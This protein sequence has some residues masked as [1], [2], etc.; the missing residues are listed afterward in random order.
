MQAAK[1]ALTLGEQVKALLEGCEKNGITISGTG[2]S[3]KNVSRFLDQS[4]H[5]PS[6]S[7][8]LLKQWKQKIEHDLDLQGVK[9]EY[10]SLFGRLV[11]EWIENPNDAAASHTR[12]RSDSDS[13]D[14][15]VSLE[16][17][18]REEMHEQRKEWESYAFN[19]KPVHEAEIEKYL[20]AL[21]GTTH[22]SKNLKRTPLEEIRYG[23]GDIENM[24][25]VRFDA[26]TVSTCIK[27]VIRADLFAG[28]K[29]EALLD[30][31]NRNDILSEMADVLNMD[32]DSLEEWEWNPQPVQLHMRRQLS[33]KYR[34]F[35]D[36]DLHQAILLQF[37]GTK[38][39]IRLK[40]TFSAFFH[41]GAWLNDP[42]HAIGKRDR[43]RRE[44]FL[45]NAAGLRNKYTVRDARRTEFHNDSF[46]TQLSNPFQGA[47]RDYGD[48]EDED[49]HDPDERKTPMATKQGMLRLATTELLINT[50][51]YGEFTILQSDFKWFG[52]SLPHQT[53][54]TVLK[55]F[56]VKDKWLSFIRKFL[57]TPLVFAQDGEDGSVRKRRR[58]IPMSHV[59][60]DTLGE[61]VLFCLDFAV[62]QRTKGGNIYRFHD[63]LW[64]WGQESAC[65]DAWKAMVEF[66]KVMGLE[67]NEEKTGTMQVSIRNPGKKPSSALPVG[68]VRWGFLK[69]DAESG[70]WLIDQ[71]EVE[72][73]IAEL[74]R[75]LAACRSVFAW[76]QAYNSYVDRFFSTNFGQPAR[77]FG[78]EH[79]QMQIETFEHI[80]RKLF[81]GDK[82]G[83]ANVTDYLREVIKE[84]FGV[85]DLPNG[86]FYLPIELGGLELRSP[87]I[88]LFMQV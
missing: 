23:L 20:E 77:C 2:I 27:G 52:P 51:L 53:I 1:S 61:A 36:E 49:V 35:M 6:V 44:F 17:V 54:F 56:G 3:L 75:Q 87:F 40:A 58:G 43:E 7:P 42:F 15:T 70:R 21:F 29:R 33:G 66:S 50:R 65:V 74:K 72:Q 31:R 71:T 55:F 82:G 8:E 57:E 84:R 10:A 26:N 78:K 38:F 4:K 83:D 14:S 22:K 63:D 81:G 24:H 37:I 64:F 18:G 46:M 13:S 32:L 11:S 19:P 59:L 30:L 28:P 34:V 62:N 85:T 80:Q 25:P 12:K 41:S 5:D 47:G 39:S 45:G 67:L 88:P 86:F 9:Y 16:Q 60:S 68:P 76:V 69:L 79:V 48:D 73:H